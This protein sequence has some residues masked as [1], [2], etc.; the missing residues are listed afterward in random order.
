M[1]RFSNFINESSTPIISTDQLSWNKGT[2]TFSEYVSDLRGIVGGGEKEII[3]NNPK[4]GASV[5]FTFTKA[6]KDGSGEDT[7]GWNYENK[8]KG[9]HLLIIND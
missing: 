7:Y 4:T 3:V 5:T 2:Q 6:D 1:K 9:L 8:E